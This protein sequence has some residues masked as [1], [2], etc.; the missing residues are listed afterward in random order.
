MKSTFVTL[1]F[2]VFFTITASANNSFSRADKS[3][4]DT[5]VK[6]HIAAGLTKQDAALIR[7]AFNLQSVLGNFVWPDWKSSKAP[8]L[9]KT[10]E[11]DYLI[12][13]PNPPEDFKPFYDKTWGGQIMVRANKDTLD[14]QA[15]YPISNITTV[16][17]TEPSQDYDPYLWVLKAVH[18]LFHVYQ[19]SDRIVNP[20][21]G[22]YKDKHELSFPFDYSNNYILAECRIE[23]ELL[24]N[25]V[26][27]KELTEGDSTVSRRVFKS[28][29]KIF[30]GTFSD[31]LQFKYKQWMEWNEGVAKYTEQK[32]AE[33]AQNPSNYKP[34]KEFS[35]LFPNS[36]FS[37]LWNSIYAGQIFPIRF[38]GEGVTGRMMFYYSG[39]AKALVLDRIHPDWRTHYFLN[40]LD[41]LITEGSNNIKC[42]I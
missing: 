3:N 35:D 7:E 11:T 41:A 30:N 16:V 25:L 27:K 14:Y 8:F 29:L 13:H 42:K 22:A 24:F 36:S 40:T 2:I 17:I 32:M 20:F 10:H 21:V 12:N 38:I 19:G 37:K 33:L 31:S 18:E 6:K 39:M 34:S 4:N 23:A 28:M 15:A 1:M 26:T 5:E 9:Y